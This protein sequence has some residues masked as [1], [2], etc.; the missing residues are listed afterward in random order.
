M[1]KISMA[2]M[3]EKIRA[4]ELKMDSVQ[5]QSLDGVV[6][7]SR[8]SKIERLKNDAILLD[9]QMR[10]NKGQINQIRKFSQDLHNRID[11]QDMR[12][13]D[14]QNKRLARGER[15]IELERKVN[16]HN[17]FLQQGSLRSVSKRPVGC[18]RTKLLILACF[19]GLWGI[20]GIYVFSWYLCTFFGSDRWYDL[21]NCAFLGVT[22]FA[23]CAMSAKTFDKRAQTGISE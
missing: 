13:G 3:D 14:I 7:E 18:K 19:W 21:P 23:L 15:M 2:D 20:S 12:I 17:T 6:L 10:D 1:S 9:G 16:V 5:E 8:L 11:A 4:L 22:A